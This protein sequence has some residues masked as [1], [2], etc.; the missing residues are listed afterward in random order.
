M[1]SSF[2][3]YFLVFIFLIFSTY[4][5]GY[6]KKNYSI[7][8]SIKEILIENEIATNLLELKSDMNFLMNSSL[9]FVNDEK[10][11]NIISKHEFITSIELEKKYPNSLKIKLIEKIPVATQIIDKKKFYITKNNEKINYIYLKIYE[12]LPTIFGKHKNFNIFYSSLKNNNFKINDIK[13]FY[14]FEVGRWDI[15]LKNEQIVKFPDK[16]YLDLLPKINLMLNDKNFFKYK[17]FD[18]RIKNQLILE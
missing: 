13:A 17:V 11:L 16:N 7:F 5:R 9:L 4:N 14:Y 12:N 2:K 10:I 15:V 18:F 8:F 6:N 3:I 1:K